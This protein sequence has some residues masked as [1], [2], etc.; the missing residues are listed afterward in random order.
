LPRNRLCDIT[1]CS[2]LAADN[3]SS[4][5]PTAALPNQRPLVSLDPARLTMAGESVPRPLPSAKRLPSL[6]DVSFC[7]GRLLPFPG[8]RASAPTGARLSGLGGH[9]ALPDERMGVG[10]KQ[11]SQHGLR[12]TRPGV[13][14]REGDQS[15]HH[16]C[17]ARSGWERRPPTPLQ[18]QASISHARQSRNAPRQPS[19]PCA[20]VCRSLDPARRAECICAAAAGGAKLR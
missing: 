11:G 18:L 5:R 17:S 16:S 6:I 3:G 13:A 9:R 15:A 14:G 8:G 2:D 20:R 1:S 10:G 4:K 19:P 7:F 12:A